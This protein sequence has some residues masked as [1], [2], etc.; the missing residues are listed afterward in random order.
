MR[1]N[2][3]SHSKWNATLGPSAAAN[4]S[5]NRAWRD[6]AFVIRHEVSYAGALAQVVP[7]G[8]VS[9]GTLCCCDDVV[10]YNQP[11]TDEILPKVRYQRRCVSYPL[12]SHDEETFRSRPGG[13]C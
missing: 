2:N 7:R 9:Q 8:G 12:N 3:L 11:G 10:E 1:K 4:Y 13:W 5:A 6:A